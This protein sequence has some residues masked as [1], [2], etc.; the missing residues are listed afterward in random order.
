MK[1]MLLIGRGN[2][3]VDSEALSETVASTVTSLVALA[4]V[5]YAEDDT[6][7]TT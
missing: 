7:D 4:N 5:G 2:E 1:I 3:L 6:I